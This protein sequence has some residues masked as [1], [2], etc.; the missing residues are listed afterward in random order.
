MV[1]CAFS[2][3]P[4]DTFIF[5]A[6]VHGKIESD[7]AITAQLHDIAVL[8]AQA[9]LGRYPI[10]KVSAYC[11]GKITKDYVMLRTGA[12]IGRGGGPK[13]VALTSRP[14][15]D[16]ILAIPGVNTTAHFLS[17]ILLD[18][19]KELLFLP[20]HDIVPAI[21][22]GQCDAGVII[23]ETRFSFA[24]HGL[25]QLADLGTLFEER[26]H[27]PLPLGVIAAKRSLGKTV[28][29]SIEAT[30]Q[31]SIAFAKTYPQSSEAY[32]ASLSQ[33]KERSVIADHI[34]LYVNEETYQMSEQALNGMKTLFSV[35]IQKNLLPQS[36]LEFAL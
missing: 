33:E 35:A 24:Q 2:P 19:P 7:I 13:L 5:D 23:H 14:I 25:Q 21:L 29:T 17:Q 11:L 4:N 20:Y 31:R 6:W 22:S 26:F 10:T 3:C 32:I 16:L 9:L 28:L 18:Q 30:I 15:H 36:A 8:N 12:A 27:C 34:N 1:E